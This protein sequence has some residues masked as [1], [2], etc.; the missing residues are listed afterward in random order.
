MVYCGWAQYC[1]ARVVGLY[2]ECGKSHIL[3]PAG[4]FMCGRYTVTQDLE[5]LGARFGFSAPDIAFRP[6][7]NLAP[8]QEA[9]VVVWDQARTVKLMRWGLVPHWAK[10]ASFGYKTI[11]AR[12]ETVDQ[13]PSFREP[14]RRRRCLVLADGFYEWPRASGRRSKQPSR[15]VLKDEELFAFAGLWDAWQTPDGGRLETFTI[16]TTQ[17]NEL[18]G[19]VHERM[20]VILSPEGEEAWLDPETRSPAGLSP[21]LKPYPSEL[22]AGYQVSPAVN[23]PPNDS[24]ECIRA[25]NELERE[26]GGGLF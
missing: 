1:P 26:E 10:E 7:Y 8:G 5:A 21:L 20:P 23:S 9:P 19:R 22:M 18:V 17:A 14:M 12:A 4:G 15:F 3:F 24:P 6:R 11:N 2:W 25:A 16:I 13:K